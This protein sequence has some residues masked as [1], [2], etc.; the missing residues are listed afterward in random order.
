MKAK[1]PYPAAPREIA[2]RAAR[3]LRSTTFTIALCLV[4][5]AAGTAGSVLYRGNT[6]PGGNA[7]FNVFRSPLFLVPACLLVANVLFCSVSR[8]RATGICTLRSCAFAGIHLGLVLCAAGL[9]ADGL[10]GFLG[11]GYYFVGVPSGAH[12][13]WR[14]GQD[15]R[16][17]FLVDVR[18]LRVEYH[19]LNLMIGVKDPQGKK[20]GPYEVREGVAFRPEGA[21]IVI[22]PRRF[23][24]ATRTLFFDA[25]GGSAAAARLAAGPGGSHPVD[26]YVV[27]PVAFHDP[28]PSGYTAVIRFVGPLGAAQEKVVRVN[29]PA[30]Y[31]G[32]TFC[33]VTQGVDRYGNAYVGLQATREPGQPLF[34]MGALL[35][36]LCAPAHFFAA[37]RAPKKARAKHLQKTPGAQEQAPA[38]PGS[39]GADAGSRPALLPAAVLLAAA[40]LIA[41]T[42]AA[43]AFGLV[44]DRDATWENEVRVAEPVTVEKGARLVIRP[45]T[46]VLL[47]GDDRDGNGCRDGYI[48]VLGSLAVEGEKDRPVR[49]APLAPGRM[50]EEVF[51]AGA[52]AVIRFAV[53][54]G[55][56]W[57]LHVHDGDVTVEQ[58]LFRGNEGGARVRGTGTRFSR[59]TFRSNGIGLRF[60]DGGPVVSASVFEGNETGIFYREG[61]GGGKIERSRFANREWD[62]KIGDWAEGVVDAS[63]NYWSSAGQQGA[64]RLFLDYRE[65]RGEGAHL[66][67]VLR[68]PPY[69]CGA[70]LEEER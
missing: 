29:S 53:F 37:R 16:Y 48:V 60:W 57:G 18:D 36:G 38:G 7:L 6:A 30:R 50:W 39:P 14:A 44:I 41:G 55:A 24:I 11:T 20:L 32:I 69:P 64:P 67:P 52:K 49:F 19:P 61:R 23:D 26:G 25:R 28:E 34:W 46:R 3:L 31:A 54:E 65:G 10:F 47:S 42:P 9:A 5:A 33:L 70:D 59:C 56:R 63:M 8:L 43:S 45:G 40:W 12:F 35:F 15:A 1:A 68:K 51:L 2:K 17:P 66:F 22:T 13:D 27:A 58:A 4:L 21:S 62:L